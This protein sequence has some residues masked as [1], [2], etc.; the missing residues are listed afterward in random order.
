M[1]QLSRGLEAGLNAPMLYH[2]CVREWL[3]KR[4]AGL[5]GKTKPKGDGLLHAGFKSLLGMSPPH[6]NAW[7]EVLLIPLLIQLPAHM[8]VGERQQKMAPAPEFLRSTW[9]TQVAFW[10]P[11]FGLA[12]PPGVVGIWAVDLWGLKISVCLSNEN[13]QKFLN[14]KMN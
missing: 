9:E 4:R 5:E 13:K 1:A 3:G 10:T 14:Y 11:G 7:A 8:H 12:Q 2:G 6:P